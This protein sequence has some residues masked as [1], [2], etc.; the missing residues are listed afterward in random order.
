MELGC[1]ICL[2]EL[3]AHIAR[4]AAQLNDLREAQHSHEP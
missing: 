3:Q 1:L 2:G 4:D